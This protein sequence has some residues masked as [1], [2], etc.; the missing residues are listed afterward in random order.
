MGLLLLPLL[1]L[2]KVK[3][4]S[5]LLSSVTKCI[6]HGDNNSLAGIMPVDKYQRINIKQSL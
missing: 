6:L 1:S 3:R 5:S 2:N 4:V